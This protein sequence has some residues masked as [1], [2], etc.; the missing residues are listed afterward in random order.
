MTDSAS[1]NAPIHL[2]LENNMAKCNLLDCER[3]WQKS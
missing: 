2:K 3:K 1:I